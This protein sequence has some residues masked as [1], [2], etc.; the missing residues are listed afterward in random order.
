MPT[1][2]RSSGWHRFL[3]NVVLAGRNGKPRLAHQLA[4]S[5]ALALVLSL[6]AVDEPAEVQ[7]LLSY[8]NVAAYLPMAGEFASPTRLFLLWELPINVAFY[9]PLMLAYSFWQAAQ[10]NLLSPALGAIASQPRAPSPAE[11]I[12]LYP[13]PSQAFDSELAKAPCEQTEG[14]AWPARLVPFPVAP[15]TLSQMIT[16]LPKEHWQSHP[17][18]IAWKQLFP[19]HWEVVAIGMQTRKMRK[20]RPVYRLWGPRGETVIAKRLPKE[21][22]QAERIIYQEFL[23]L[24]PLRTIRFRGL[25]EEP[26]GEF[27]WLFLEDAA[28]EPYSAQLH[29]HRALAGKW[30]GEV[31]LASLSF[32]FRGRLPSREA[33]YYLRSLRGSRTILVDHLSHN[34]AML[35]DDAAVFRKVVAQFDLAETHWSGIEEIC[36]AMPPTLVHGDFVAKNVRV[37]NGRGGPALLVFDWE[38]AGWGVPGTD[39]AQLEGHAHLVSPDLGIYHS[40]LQRAKT[41]LSLEEVQGVAACGSLLRLVDEMQW[42]ICD[43]KFGPR[44]FLLK[45]VETLRIY[46]PMLAEALEIL[47]MV[48]A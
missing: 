28:S 11:G 38:Y 9:A 25:L 18:A 40:V 41:Q 7:T 22:A 44:E 27:C 1:P 16:K 45:P 13:G 3:A 4:K 29:H 42:A 43:L 46:E 10:A 39:L 6:I 37:R 2:V 17:A 30:L 33:G 20:R 23:P 31:Q 34:T 32:D 36:G 21:T 19:E 14:P 35:P 48:L 15:Q 24:I 8:L 5:A 26:A 12:R 47:K